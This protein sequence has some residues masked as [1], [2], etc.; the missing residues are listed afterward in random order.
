MVL[1]NEYNNNTNNIGNPYNIGN[2]GNIAP[3]NIVPPNNYQAYQNNGMPRV[4]VTSDRPMEELINEKKGSPA[5]YILIATL[6]MNAA[7]FLLAI[8]LY[9]MNN[10]DLLSIVSLLV[11]NVSEFAFS[12]I[13]LQRN[14]YLND[15]YFH[16][17][18]SGKVTF[19]NI[20]RYVLYALMISPIANLIAS[21]ASIIFSDSTL[22]SISE[23]PLWLSIVYVSILGPIGEEMLFRGTAAYGY[24]RR[25]GKVAAA[26]ISALMFGLFHMNFLQASYAFVLGL[27]FAF[28][29]L[30]ENSILPVIMMHIANNSISTIFDNIN[31]SENTNEIVNMVYS[32]IGIPCLAIMI[33]LIALTWNKETKTEPMSTSKKVI[34]VPLVIFVVV[35]VIMCIFVEISAY[36][37]TLFN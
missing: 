35:M 24:S 15:D 1:E 37:T 18:R 2:T 21:I 12:Y 17:I 9:L 8:P 26:V 29:A 3:N 11:I 7:Q 34:D 25:N 36:S 32:I 5:L 33:I 22:Q 10:D 16:P 23:M 31:L 30:N 14:G 27:I 28:V 13:F 6:I 19:S 4:Y 20:C